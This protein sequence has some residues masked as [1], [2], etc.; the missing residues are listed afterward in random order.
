MRVELE[1]AGVAT[2]FDG[3]TFTLA[4]LRAV[5]EAIWGVQLDA[6]NFR[7]TIVARRP[8]RSCFH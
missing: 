2:A 3:T 8:G 7:R 1:V 6:A 4:K 5:Y